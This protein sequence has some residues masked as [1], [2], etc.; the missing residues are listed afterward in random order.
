MDGIRKAGLRVLHT[1]EI[2]VVSSATTGTELQH[3]H[4]LSIYF[5]WSFRDF[6]RE[7]R[8]LQ[9]AKETGWMSFLEVYLGATRR[10][11][12]FQSAHLKAANAPALPRTMPEPEPDLSATKDV[13]AGTRKYVEAGTRKGQTCRSTMKNPPEGYC[14]PPGRE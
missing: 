11:R 6:F 4:G 8:N 10:M 5:P 3:S 7:Y 12:R 1:I 2:A 14:P 9:F 13:E